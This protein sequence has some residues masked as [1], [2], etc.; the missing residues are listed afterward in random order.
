MKEMR[1]WNP[2]GQKNRI[3]RPVELAPGM[4]KPRIEYDAVTW[5]GGDPFRA[6]ANQI[7]DAQPRHRVRCSARRVPRPAPFAVRQLRVGLVAPR[8]DAELELAFL[9]ALQ[10]DADTCDAVRFVRFVP[11]PA[12]G[13]LA[14]DAVSVPRE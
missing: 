8:D 10:I 5:V 1:V 13:H 9:M 6:R 11:V 3:L 4:K 7:D 2:V 14:R 12:T